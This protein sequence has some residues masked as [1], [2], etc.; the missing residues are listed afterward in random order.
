M[1]EKGFMKQ[2]NIR[3][4]S[5]SRNSSESMPLGGHDAGCN[6][7]VQDDELCLYLS[8][9]G[10]FDENGTML[11]AGRLRLKSDAPLAPDF[12]Q[13]LDL[14]TGSIRIHGGDMDFRL[15]VDVTNADLHIEYR[16]AAAH[17]LQLTYDSW[18]YFDREV[19]NAER[20]QCRNLSGLD[21][22][23]PIEPK[24][25]RKD[26][27]LPQDETL[28]FY[29]KNDNSAL[30]FD[31]IIRQQ[32]LDAHKSVFPNAIRDLIT[33]GC[34]HAPSFRYTG[35]SKGVFETCDQMEYRYESEPL[36]QAQLVVSLET[37][38]HPSV[39][40]WL[41]AVRSKASNGQSFEENCAW[42]KEYWENS[43]IHIDEAHPG[44]AY[45]RM[46]RNVQLFRYMLG[47]NFY[48][49]F[50]TKFNGGLFTFFEAFTPD[51]RNWSGTEFTAQNQRLVYWP[52]LRMGDFEAMK[53]QFDFY[54]NML[55]GGKARAKHY[56]GIGGAYFPEQISCFG[57]SCG[58]EYR[59]D[60]DPTVPKGEENNPWTRLHYSTAPEFALMMLRCIEYTGKDEPRYAEFAEEVVRF[61]MEHYPKKEDGTLHIFP[62][63][64]LETYKGDPYAADREKFGATDPMDAIA[65]LRSVTK[66]LIRY[67]KAH[68]KDAAQYEAWRSFCPEL[69]TGEMNGKTVFLPAAQ[70]APKPFNCEMPQLY[71]VFPYSPEG[72]TDE[73]KVI[74]RTTYLEW[75]WTDDQ[76]LLCSWHQ[77]GIFAARLNLTEEAMRIHL[78]KLG[79]AP[80]RFPVFW[81]PG[82]DWTPD[83]NHGGSGLIGLQEMLLQ[84]TEKGLEFLPAWDKSVDV[85]FKMHVAG[86][87]VVTAELKDGKLTTTMQ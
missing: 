14:P 33:G 50:P 46:G 2:Y 5:Q 20:G 27:V 59:W 65:A 87:R 25:T 49:K 35:C 66:A 69:P 70:Y 39:E 28:I 10:A 55:E 41:E 63:T 52:L 36:T 15:W 76:R 4:D 74:G 51:Y 31:H 30:V 56:W 22:Y 67:A 24:V 71:R 21:E 58:A 38:Q 45:W 78:E 13:E 16:A 84:E 17:R 53:P 72:L 83:H 23:V 61:Y 11:K 48:G 75:P 64:A 77:N 62:S 73:E 7:W 54:L 57:L 80:K 18:R 60:R 3:W 68:G 82:H 19:T 43:Y 32:G 40:N 37:A 44:S 12:L 81:G 1:T 34:L 79:D 8:Q 42:W 29:H 47:C 26:T 85:R 6:V 86:S 9:S